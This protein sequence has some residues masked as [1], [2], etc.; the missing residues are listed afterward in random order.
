M[1]ALTSSCAAATACCTANR[2]SGG[3]TDGGAGVYGVEG[4][5]GGNR[6]STGRVCALGAAWG[7]ANPAATPWRCTG[8]WTA[9]LAALGSGASSRGAAPSGEGPGAWKLPGR[10]NAAGG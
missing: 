5:E 8:A 1:V 6:P 9:L 4:V 3:V 7:P 10:C 2:E